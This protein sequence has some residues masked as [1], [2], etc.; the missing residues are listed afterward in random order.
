MMKLYKSLLLSS[1][2]AM[3][4]PAFEKE[5][6]VN[7]SKVVKVSYPEVTINGTSLIALSVE[8]ACTDPEQK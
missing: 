7:I 8:S 5:T 2:L 1:I 3:I 4:L 6:T